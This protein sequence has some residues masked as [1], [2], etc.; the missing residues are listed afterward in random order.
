MQSFKSENPQFLVSSFKIKMESADGKHSEEL[1]G[2]YFSNDLKGRADVRWSQK[3]EFKP[4]K[5]IKMIAAITYYN[6][7]SYTL[8]YNS[9]TKS[10]E[11]IF[12]SDA[13]NHI[14]EK[15]YSIDIKTIPDEIYEWDPI[16]DKIKSIGNLN[17]SKKNSTGGGTKGGTT[18][19]NCDMSNYNGPE[20]DIQ[21]DSQCKTAYA[22]QCAGNEDGRKTACALYNNYKS[23]WK[24]SGSF[25]KCPYCD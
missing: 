13:N 8:W 3:T 5:G 2:N 20:F 4:H 7:K 23:Q 15:Q 21:I 16:S 12:K 24:G 17:D 19:A 14:D 22:Y 11:K 9:N 1:S 10:Y 18:G 25:P 6:E